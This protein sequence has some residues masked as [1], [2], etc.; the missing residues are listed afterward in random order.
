[1]EKR[2]RANPEFKSPQP[3]LQTI[4]DSLDGEV[5]VKDTNGIYQFVNAAFCKDFG[6]NKNEV[7]GKDDYFVFP[8]EAAAQLQE[9]DKKVMESRISEMVV[10]EGILR[11]KHLTYSTNK[12]PLID[13]DGEVYGICGIGFDITERV[14]LEEERE[15]LIKELQNVL[16][17][18]KTLKGII[19]ICASCKKIRDDK[20]SW[21]QLE[22]YITEHSEAI[23]THGICD[24]CYKKQ[25]EEFDKLYLP[26]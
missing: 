6:V 5:F 20:G 3:L 9:N 4:I 11:G 25:R 10:E 7:I 13:E 14:K 19:P 21:K 12:V 18:I 8:P 22:L 24:E 23:F 2:N 16:A 17:E 1:M 26:K 15:K